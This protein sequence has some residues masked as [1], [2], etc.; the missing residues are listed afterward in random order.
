M[1]DKSDKLLVLDLDETLIH[2]TKTKLDDITEDFRF[3]KYFVY[4]RPFLDQFL[5]EA[6]K[7]FS[8]AIW[9]SAGDEYVAE[10]VRNIKPPEIELFAVWGRSKCSQKRDRT[11]DTFYFEK[12]LDKFKKRGFPLE[13]ILIVDDTA[14]KAACN[15]GNAIYIKEYK[16]D[17]QDN[18]LLTLLDYLITLKPIDNVR[19]IEK[20]FWRQKADGT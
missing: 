15:Y 3:D 10:V 1:S 12:R 11:F 20:R 2:A 19:A 18:E 7:H 13:R 17:P 6:S 5:K 16:G 9:S 14:E 8:L 4:K